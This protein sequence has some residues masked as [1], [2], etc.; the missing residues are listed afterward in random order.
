MASG[1]LVMY[2]VFS[3]FLLL[4]QIFDVICSLIVA[5]LQLISL[6]PKFIFHKG[7]IILLAQGGYGH[8]VTDVDLARI[9]YPYKDSQSPP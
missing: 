1:R 8:T 7:P 5:F 2:V 4:L 6:L 9:L 3:C